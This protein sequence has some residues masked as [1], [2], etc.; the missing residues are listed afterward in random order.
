MSA[1]AML[2][3]VIMEARGITLQLACVDAFGP[4]RRREFRR[5]Q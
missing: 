1:I 3:R 4:G 2:R 5:F